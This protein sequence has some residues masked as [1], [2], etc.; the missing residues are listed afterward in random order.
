MR[1]APIN[2]VR[3]RRHKPLCAMIMGGYQRSWHP[4]MHQRA[5][6]L[7]NRHSRQGQRLGAQAVAQLYELGFELTVVPVRNPQHL[8]EVI[9]RHQDK[10][11]LVI[12]G[13]GDGTLNAALAGLVETQLPLGILPLGTANDLARTLGVPNSVP[14]ACE[15]LATGENRQIDLGWVNG[16]YFLNVASVG[17]STRITH[18]LTGETKR[19]WG[20]LA[21]GV[22]AMRVVW[23]TRPF[24]A[25]IR[26]DGQV[27]PVKTVQIAVGNGRFYGGGLAIAH[28]AT[29]DDQR[30]DIY[31]LELEHWWQVITLLPAMSQGRQ[32]ELPGVRT[33]HAREVVIWTR[34]P[35][36][37]NTDGELTTHTPAHF[38][39]IPQA[40]T[41]RVPQHQLAP[42]LSSI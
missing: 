29:I 15:V 5:L 13:G 41:V 31:S 26:S 2:A 3:M 40:L 7:I 38:R 6:L 11:D 17:I 1:A 28:D 14:K 23:R 30:L 16:K 8:S 20:V 19:R 25:E 37:V 35:H 36:M 24:K 10:V 12:V 18:E 21:Y 32:G 9:C 33:L 22:T 39:V 27:I 42:G 34:K 4:L